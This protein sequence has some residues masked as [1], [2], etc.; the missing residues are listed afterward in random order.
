M[1]KYG[2]LPYSIYNADETYITTVTDPGKYLAEKGQRRVGAVTSGERGSDIIIMYAKRWEGN[3]ILP[4]FIFARQ[5]ITPLL[6][7]LFVHWVKHLQQMLPKN[8]L[9]C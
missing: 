1:E 9:C 8:R 3:F 6:E 5:R 7:E 4:M 2:L